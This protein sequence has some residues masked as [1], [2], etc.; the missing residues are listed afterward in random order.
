MFWT[1]KWNGLIKD[2][3]KTLSLKFKAMRPMG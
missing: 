2:A 1:Y 3:E